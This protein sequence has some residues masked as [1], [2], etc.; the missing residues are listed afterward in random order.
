MPKVTEAI[1]NLFRYQIQEGLVNNP[2]TLNRYSSSMEVQ[3]NVSAGNGELVA[4]ARNTWDDGQHKYW[5][6]RI[7]KGAMTDAPHW[8]DYELKFPLG[9]SLPGHPEHPGYAEAIGM[10]GWDWRHQRSKWVAFDFDGITGHAKGVG[11]SEEELV[12]VQEAATNIPWVESR[13]STRGG[14][15]HL[16]V[17][18]TN[19]ADLATSGIP[20]ENHTVH[21]ALARCI[22]SMMSHHAGFD[23]SSA[24]D[25]C[26]GNM[27]V[28]HRATTKENHGLEVTHSASSILLSED[29]PAS[30]R[31]NID[32]VTKR[33]SKVRVRGVDEEHSDD[34]DDLATSRPSIKLTK[35]HEAVID[36]LMESGFS[37]IWHNDCRLFQTHTMALKQIMEKFIGKYDGFF[38]TNSHGN[39][40]GMPNC[41]MFPLPGK[42]FK[43]YRFSPGI[44]ESDSWSQDGKTW[45][46]CL[47]DRKPTLE[48]A[49][50][51][52]KG[53]E[54]GEGHFVFQTLKDARQC[55]N[56]VG[57]DIAVNI[58]AYG[59]RS[60]QIRVMKNGRV[61]LWIKAEKNEVNP[62]IGWVEKRGGWWERVIKGVDISAGDTVENTTNQ[63]DHFVRALKS[64]AD[65]NA[66]WS[67]FD[68]S[69][70][71]I[72]QPSA[73]VRLA[74]GKKSGL[75]G[76][77]LDD[78][79]GEA[80]MG[81]WQL[82]NLPFH[83]EYPG[84]R[85]WNLNAA[86]W[87]F[88]PADLE[89][90][91]EPKHPHWDMIFDH[92]GN[93]LTPA[94]KNHPW[95][96]RHGVRTGRQYLQM[97]AASL[98]RYPFDKLPY[99]FLHGPENSGKSTLHI[100]ISRLMTDGFIPA[101]NALRSDNDFNGEFCN[102]VL[103]V[104]EE[105]NP[106]DKNF[107]L[108]KARMKDWTTSDDIAIRR[109][110]MDVYRQ[111]NTL[112]FIQCSNNRDACLASVGDTRITMMYVPAFIE[113]EEVPQTI[114]NKRL[115]DEAPHFMRTLVDLDIPEPEGR[116]RVPYIMTAGKERYEEFQ[117]TA[118]EIFIEERC[119]LWPGKTVLWKEFFNK[120]HKELSNDDPQGKTHW[121]QKRV[122]MELPEQF[123]T[124]RVGQETQF[125]VGNM[126]L[127][128]KT[129]PTGDDL[130]QPP[131]NKT[132]GRRLS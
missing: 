80:V 47:F 93:D 43:V 122:S 78:I 98:L 75:K 110:R 102:A 125:Y 6:I 11:I 46:T 129:P 120:F 126:V 21:A 103:A 2:E 124:G 28:W 15:I 20:T 82:I 95:A 94:L 119:T 68:D 61:V 105:I 52:A 77:D 109:M 39:N 55:L 115:E 32:V 42:G 31:D 67:I 85:Q 30:W 70:K 132:K 63:W 48:L 106:R 60:S 72:R 37:T 117:K 114:L 58:E 96:M 29:I 81:A 112:H 116:L 100:A 38:E 71:W 27:W 107:L 73:N 34:L 19:P 51:M 53:A 88:Q 59:H 91:E 111:R 23:F 25:C 7:P 121:S 16:Y 83:P 62:G 123:P 104:V 84:G 69:E 40:P 113:A 3:V 10:T 4:A 97:W 92:I 127:D 90:N 1:Q 13:L 56:F 24:I 76:R 9:P 5:H 101:N 89:I 35:H 41:F 131:L 45:T 36:D 44:T 130:R 79:Q 108:A 17:Y 99:L 8:R 86:Q 65:E 128:C 66:G 64:T 118:L 74:L 33:R 18:F 87:K 57:T 14:G 54:T 26:G 22:L 50:Q 12:K 49:A